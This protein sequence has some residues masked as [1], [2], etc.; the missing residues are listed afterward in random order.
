MHVEQHYIPIF[1]KILTESGFLL[2]LIVTFLQVKEIFVDN[3]NRGN[4]NEWS[5]FYFCF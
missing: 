4:P 1:E 3:Y 2:S 5:D